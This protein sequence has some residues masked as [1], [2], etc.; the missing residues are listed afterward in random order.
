MST[1]VHHN[2]YNLHQTPTTEVF[3]LTFQRAK[4]RKCHKQT[5]KKN[6]NP[7]RLEC[8]NGLKINNYIN[9]QPSF[10]GG[11]YCFW[12][13]S[14]I[15]SNTFAKNDKSRIYTYIKPTSL[16]KFKKKK[17]ATFLRKKKKKKLKK[18]KKKKTEKLQQD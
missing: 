9:V 12:I 3:K 5:N 14:I 10:G 7:A 16:K 4:F 1:G 15:R 18:K 6:H 8:W 11:L 13:S 17:L 2:N